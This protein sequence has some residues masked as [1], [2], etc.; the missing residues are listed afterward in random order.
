MGARYLGMRVP[1][2]SKSKQ[3]NKTRAGTPSKTSSG[4]SSCSSHGLDAPR[5]ARRLFIQ[6]FFFKSSFPESQ[7]GEQ[8][9][10][11]LT[12]QGRWEKVPE[13][14]SQLFACGT[15]TPSLWQQRWGCL[16]DAR[17]IGLG[18]FSALSTHFLHFHIR[19]ADQALFGVCKVSV[20]EAL[21]DLAFSAH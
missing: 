9:M 14:P 5:T 2:Q 1:I 8:V 6:T 21:Q 4:H 3:A 20:G 10:A 7:Y 19:C 11:E 15:C 18:S 13:E 16:R 12:C 17:H